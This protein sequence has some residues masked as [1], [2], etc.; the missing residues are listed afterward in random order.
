[1][2][3]NWIKQEKQLTPKTSLSHRTKKV[4]LLLTVLSSIVLVLG[5]LLPFLDNI[6]NYYFP[7]E[8]KKPFGNYPNVKSAIYFF[9]VLVCPAIIL[10]ASK[11]HPYWITYI[12]PMFSYTI[13]IFGYVCMIMGYHFDFDLIA[14]ILF[15]GASLFL[16]IFIRKIY[17]KVSEMF[18][19]EELEKEIME[20]T[21]KYLEKDE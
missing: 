6:L 2:K 10:L 19:A 4:R 14:Y 21:L 15:L 17:R 3:K 7:E 16:V 9:S 12:F 20:R 11:L 5:G 18:L 1:M 8:L 13:M